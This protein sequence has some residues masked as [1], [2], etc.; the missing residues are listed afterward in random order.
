ML[1]QEPWVSYNRKCLMYTTSL[2]KATQAGASVGKRVFYK[3]VLYESILSYV[4][5]YPTFG[6]IG[7]FLYPYSSK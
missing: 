6:N 7:F 4:I 2:A 3:T 1:M 5:I